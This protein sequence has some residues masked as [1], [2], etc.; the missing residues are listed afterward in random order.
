MQE[1]NLKEAQFRL[2]VLEKGLYG[3]EILMQTRREALAARLT[4]AFTSE[5]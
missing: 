1:S 3:Y 4:E 2:R 5:A